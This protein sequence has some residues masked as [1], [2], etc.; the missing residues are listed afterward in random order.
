MPLIVDPDSDA[1]R[2]I[3]KQNR[4][5]QFDFMYMSWAIAQYGIGL[6]IDHTFICDLNQYATHYISPQPGRYRRHYHV[7]VREH[8]PSEWLHV[9]D[10]MEQFLEVLYAQWGKCAELQA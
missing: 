10:E 1:G 9:H 5:R 6:D 3:S 2:F 8:R 4:A 7:K